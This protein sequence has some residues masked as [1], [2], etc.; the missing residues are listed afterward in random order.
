MHHAKTIEPD[1]H[2]MWCGMRL[3]RVVWCGMLLMCVVWC[4][5]LLMRWRRMWCVNNMRMCCGLSMLA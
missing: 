5:M 2:V 3:M 4:G 1:V